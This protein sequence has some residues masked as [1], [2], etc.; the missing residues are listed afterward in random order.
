V[1][2][3]CRKYAERHAYDSLVK[4]IL[5]NYVDVM[6]EFF[7]NNVRLMQCHPNRDVIVICEVLVIG[8]KLVSLIGSISISDLY[9]GK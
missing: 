1:Q 5:R 3:I 4:G 7:F 9:N 2:H 8:P 6:A